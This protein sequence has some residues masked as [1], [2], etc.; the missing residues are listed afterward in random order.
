MNKVHWNTVL[1][2]GSIP[3]EEVYGQI[4]HSYDL[5]WKSLTKKARV[6]IEAESHPLYLFPDDAYQPLEIRNDDEYF[7]NGIFVFNITRLLEHIAS[8]PDDY[9]IEVIRVEDYKPQFNIIEHDK[10]AF[11]DLESPIIL[12]E[13]APVRYNVIDGHHRINKAYHEG[14]TTLKAYKLPPKQHSLFITEQTAYDS[15][16][17][18]WNEKLKY[19]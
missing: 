10:C 9:Q 3:D 16:L 4:D 12:A 14:V 8:K 18:Y 7:R 19:M 5:I 1:C 2:D 17:E 6:Q 15:Y 11:A 13:I